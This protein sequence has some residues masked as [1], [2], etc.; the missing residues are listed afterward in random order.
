MKGYHF[1]VL[2]FLALLFPDFSPARAQLAPRTSQ[3][4]LNKKKSNLSILLCLRPRL[5]TVAV[6]LKVLSKISKSSL[7]VM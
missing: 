1:K 7:R 6:N 3:Q 2:T 5:Y 4:D